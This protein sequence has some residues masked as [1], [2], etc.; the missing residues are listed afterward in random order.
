MPSARRNLAQVEYLAQAAP[1]RYLHH[2]GTAG[3][4]ADGQQ[5]GTR[6]RARAGRGI[7]LRTEHRE[8]RQLGEGLGVGQQG[9]T[10]VNPALAGPDLAARR[11]RRAAVDG[12][13]QGAGLAGHESLGNLHYPRHPPQ[14][15]LGRH[16][17]PHRTSDQGI[18]DADDERVRPQRPCRRQGP[19]Q[20]EVRR[21]QQQHPVLLAPRLAF[22]AVH[23]D[24]RSA[25]ARP[26]RPQHG[27]E[28]PRD[29]E[30]G[31]A[32]A[33]QVGLLGQGD[34][35]SGLVSRH[36]RRTRPGRSP[37]PPGRA[38]RGQR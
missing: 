36:A 13:D 2:R 5:D 34:Q 30:R 33:A 35:L 25:L 15:R 6:L 4:A 19:V 18:G 24:D 9:G 16:R 10:S 32:A 7:A 38:G 11:K 17:L 22:G 3:R 26:G 12:V 21:P 29:R 28:F 8:H 14:G 37:G 1:G 23:H 31:A 27:R 20:D